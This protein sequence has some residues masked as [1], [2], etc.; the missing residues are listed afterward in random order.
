VARSVSS[1]I[2]RQASPMVFRQG[3]CAMLGNLV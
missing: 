1:S 2:A 3:D